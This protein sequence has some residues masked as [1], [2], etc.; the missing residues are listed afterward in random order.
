V[1]TGNGGGSDRSKVS[2]F[3]LT[4]ENVL[5]LVIVWQGT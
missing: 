3:L 1:R 2:S 4:C 5:T